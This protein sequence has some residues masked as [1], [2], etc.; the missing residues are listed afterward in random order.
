[1]NWGLCSLS[2]LKFYILYSFTKDHDFEVGIRAIAC[3][4]DTDGSMTISSEEA[5][6]KECVQ[7]Q[8]W[9]TKTDEVPDGYNFL[10]IYDCFW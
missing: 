7:F 4:C 2:W 9:I 6:A 8:R 3:K 1:M 5:N 10:G